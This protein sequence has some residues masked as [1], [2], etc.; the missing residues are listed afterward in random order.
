MFKRITGRSLNHDDDLPAPDWFR[1]ATAR[2]TDQWFDRVMEH[3]VREAL[4]WRILLVS[5]ICYLAVWRWM[6]VCRRRRLLSPQV[7]IRVPSYGSID[8]V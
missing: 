5:L 4:V 2:D 1:N 8:R 7:E 6:E 3:N